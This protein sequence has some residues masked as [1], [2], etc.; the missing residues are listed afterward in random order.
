MHINATFRVECPWLIFIKNFAQMMKL[1]RFHRFPI[2]YFDNL[3]FFWISKESLS[4]AENELHENKAK[5]E[6]RK[7]ESKNPRKFATK[8]LAKQ[9]W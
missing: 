9:V 7:Q 8:Q 3:F 6:K 5:L 4:K 2:V 1:W